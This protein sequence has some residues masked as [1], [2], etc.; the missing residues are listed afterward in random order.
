MRLPEAVTDA[1]WFLAL[2]AYIAATAWLLIW[3]P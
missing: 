3:V 1:L 2:A